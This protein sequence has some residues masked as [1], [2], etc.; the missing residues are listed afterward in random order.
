MI[1]L[2]KKIGQRKKMK[3]SVL[4]TLTNASPTILVVMETAQIQKEVLIVIAKTVGR[5]MKVET[6]LTTLMN[7]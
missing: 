3:S 7:A 6:A 1:V 5:R 2:V 4:R